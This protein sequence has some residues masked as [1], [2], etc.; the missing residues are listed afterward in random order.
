MRVK[1]Y[2]APHLIHTH[3]QSVDFS[4]SYLC[5][6]ATDISDG[7]RETA[8]ENFSS[9]RRPKVLRN[10]EISMNKKNDYADINII[11]LRAHHLLCSRLFTG[12]G[13]DDK[14][15]ERMGETAS[16]MGVG[17]YKDSAALPRA[18]KVRLICGS[19][20][21]CE[22]CPNRFEETDGHIQNADIAGMTHKDGCRLGTED[23][24]LKDRLTLKYAGLKENEE[25]TPEELEKSVSLINK[26]Q[27]EEI[28][29][30]CR[31]YKAGY[32][33]YEALYIYRYEK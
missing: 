1:K 24:R 8:H 9:P 2:F 30:S 29:G 19:D 14:F 5:R 6:S 15:T 25:Y 13:Y 16:R 3:S 18:A 12:H 10:G 31:W 26:S 21:V 22:M 23:V 32:C 7:R 33:R 28:C 17:Y 20:Y 27:F 4:H 11:T